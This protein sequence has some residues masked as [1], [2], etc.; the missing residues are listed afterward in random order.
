MSSGKTHAK[1]SLI[2]SA[3]FCVSYLASGNPLVFEMAIGSLVG[4]FITPD[5]DLSN[6][7]VVNGKFIKR[8]LGDFPLRAWKLL[9]K[10]YSDS[11]PHGSWASHFPIFSTYVRLFYIFFMVLVP[12]Y[13]VYSLILL[14]SNYHI[15]LITEALWWCKIMFAS[16][17]TVGLCA[18]DLIHYSL[19]VMTKNVD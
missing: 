1:A 12:F 4:I 8:K 6:G 15:I 2:L 5:L 11:F 14:S 16:W 7:G 13:V 19:D 3:G 17:Y 18:S 9:W 10:K